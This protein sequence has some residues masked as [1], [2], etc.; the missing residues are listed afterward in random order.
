MTN[1]GFE[2]VPPPPPPAETKNII[3]MSNNCFTETLR[4]RLRARHALHQ[5]LG[6]RQ[7][8]NLGKAVIGQHTWM[9]NLACRLKA[10][11]KS[12]DCSCPTYKP[13]CGLL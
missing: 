8:P 3:L 6:G 9:F 13:G 4:Q 10:I 5:P 12:V 2:V 1:L 7:P 11:L